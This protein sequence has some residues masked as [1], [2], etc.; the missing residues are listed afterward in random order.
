M[1]DIKKASEWDEF[2]WEETEKA[3]SFADFFYTVKKL[4]PWIVLTSLLGGILAWVYYKT[5]EPQYVVKAKILIKDDKGSGGMKNMDVFQS[6]GLLTGSSSVDNELEIITTY[7]IMEKVVKDLGLNVATKKDQF[8]NSV[9]QKIYDVPWKAAVTSYMP[10]AFENIGA[11]TFKVYTEGGKNWLMDGDNKQY[12]NWNMPIKTSVGYLKFALRPNRK[13]E[14]GEWLLTIEKPSL[15]TE[16]YI[17]NIVPSVPNKN[18]SIITLEMKTSNP[19]RDRKVMNKLIE[20]YVQDGVK[21]NNSINDSTLVFINDR[22]AEVTGELR[23]VEGAIQ[24]FKQ[25]NQLTDIE[26][27]IKVLLDATKENTQKLIDAEIQFNVASSLE[28]HLRAGN[29]VIPSSLLLPDPSLSALV[30]QYNTLV[31]QRDRLG[32]TA[33]PENPLMKGLSTQIGSVRSEL[34]SGI[35]SMRRSHGTVVSELRNVVN[36]NMGYIRKVPQLER[37]F[38]DISRQQ[39]IKQELY[40]FLLKKREETA[41]GKSSTLSNTRVIDY[42]R[43]VD[44]PVSPKRNMILLA[45]LLA[46]ALLPLIVSFI[47]RKTNLKLQNKNDIRS[48]T[49][50]PVLGEIG[51]QENASVF[52]VKENPRSALAEQFRILRTNL[53]FYQKEE[54]ATVVMVTSSISGEGKT[55]VSLNLAAT[56]AANPEVKVLVIGMDLRKPRLATELNLKHSEG[57]SNYIVKDVTLDQIIYPLD[58]F[59]NLFVMPSG[60]IP[61][62]PSELLMSKSTGAMFRE[63]RQQFDFIVID[64]PPAVV[65]DYQIISQYADIALYISR[66]GYTEKRQLE[67]ADELYRSGKLPK[68]SLVVN[69]F[70]PDNYDGYS[71]NYYY[72]YGYYE[73]DYTRKPFYKKWFSKK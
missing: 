12:F 7:S 16:N 57:F 63:I 30:N 66:I 44:E 18:T 37:E 29:N 26:D 64:C 69:D 8:F 49:Q 53:H 71:S 9:D 48:R 39:A 46:G 59:R 6:L 62:N 1:N 54:G 60:S 10:D 70:D 24:N 40:L 55:F 35:S 13:S 34:L 31:V 5:Q 50:M 51:H 67:I 72:Q 17:Q 19:A 41:I 42:A 21:D 36:Q 22:L 23:D 56:L 43:V 45:G 73:T 25:R 11:Y 3:T 38:L 4:L 20:T 32:K 65:T 47:R 33:T 61:P 68:M 15:T 52:E 2:E 28:S 27:Q 58:G 14:N